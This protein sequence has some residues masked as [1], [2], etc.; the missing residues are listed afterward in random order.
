MKSTKEKLKKEL[1]HLSPK[2]TVHKVTKE[3]GGLILSKIAGELPLKQ[4]QD[5]NIK[6]KINSKVWDTQD[7]V[8]TRDIWVDKHRGRS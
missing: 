2:E 6:H 5:Y 4:Q 3:R 1:D 7:N 8:Y